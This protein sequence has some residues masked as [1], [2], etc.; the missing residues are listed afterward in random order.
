MKK[1]SCLVVILASAL[2]GIHCSKG[3]IKSTGL[4]RVADNV[5]AF[6]AAGPSADEGLGANS[7][8]VVGDEAVLV[9]DSR[10][11]P[12][13]AGQ[14][15]ESIRSLTD[16]PVR[17]VINTHYHPDHTWGNSAFSD[18]G[19][20]IIARPETRDA[21]E[22]YTPIYMQYYRDEKPETW[23]RL[24]NVRMVLPDSL[25]DDRLRID[26]GGIAVELYHLGAG[27]TAGDVFVFVPSARTVFAGGLVSNGYHVNM[28]DQGAD[29]ANWKAILGKLQGMGIERV[30]PGQGNVCGK[31]A[32]ARQVEYLDA[33]I[34]AGKTAI[35]RMKTL[36]EAVKTVDIPSAAGYLQANMVPFNLQSIYRKYLFEVVDPDFR[37]DLPGAFAASDGGGDAQ[38]GRLLWILQNE[39]GYSELDVSWQPTSRAEVIR[40]DIH[41]A[42]ADY[43]GADDQIDMNIKGSKKI[44]VGGLDALAV[45]GDWGYSRESKVV[46]SGLWTWAM[47]VDGGKVYS[48]RMSTNAGN[49]LEKETG[50]MEILEKT[51][52]TF[53]HV[54]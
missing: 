3:D 40:Q 11:T 22:K 24:M 42:I 6:I 35:R 44:V 51:A 13:L 33:M 30:V 21:I 28:S 25:M 54:R 49:I 15:Y 16:L 45:Y 38:R 39:D 41:D 34:T 10:Q 27:H 37:F 20:S 43:L 1:R 18:R 47:I 17:Y 2:F 7:G 32:L 26:L 36:S 14:L 5:Y 46:G 12:E 48:I 23:R 52:T 29:F 31:E 50:N 8:F 9:V 4:V 53:R 19:A